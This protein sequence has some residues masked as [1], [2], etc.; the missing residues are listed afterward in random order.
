[1]YHKTLRRLLAASLAVPLALTATTVTAPAA[2][3]APEVAEFTGG[4]TTYCDLPTE[5]GNRVNGPYSCDHTATS[6]ICMTA[7]RVGST[8]VESYTC[9][10]HLIEGWTEG[11]ATAL[12]NYGYACAN[13]SGN[14][15]FEY[16]PEQGGPSRRFNVWLQVTGTTIQISGSYFDFSSGAIVQVRASIPAHCVDGIGTAAGYTGSVFPF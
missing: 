4:F 1:M 16:T 8:R 6:A 10:A 5:G 3:A 13:G 15:T 12:P 9:S 11:A 14:G 7:A 2:H